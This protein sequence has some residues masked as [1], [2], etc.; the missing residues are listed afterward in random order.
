MKS[1][2]SWFEHCSESLISIFS[3]SPHGV[4]IHPKHSHWLEHSVPEVARDSRPMA[5]ISVLEPFEHLI[6]DVALVWGDCSLVK[7]TVS[8]PLEHSGLG[9]TDDV[10]MDSLWMAQ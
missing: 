8:D 6:P 4:L 5:G 2:W 7:M 10:D 3:S 1:S 9:E